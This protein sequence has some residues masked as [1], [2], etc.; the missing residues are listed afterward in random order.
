MQ[1]F[2]GR[3]KNAPH[4]RNYFWRKRTLFG[5]VSSLAVSEPSFRLLDRYSLPVCLTLEGRGATK[6]PPW[7]PHGLCPEGPRATV[8]SAPRCEG[9]ALCQTR[10]SCLCPSGGSWSRR[11]REWGYPVARVRIQTFGGRN[12]QE[13]L[14]FVHPFAGVKT[15]AQKED[16]S[17][18]GAAFGA[19]PRALA[20]LL[21]AP[22]RLPGIDLEP[23]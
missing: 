17:S 10:G 23:S 4:P 21:L 18:E 8:L 7:G 6:Q 13:P 2:F 16:W 12:T 9:S 15:Q 11:S 1:P 19:C 22:S 14:C 3:V 20:H 5:Q